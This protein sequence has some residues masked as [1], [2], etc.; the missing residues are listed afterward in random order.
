VLNR[1][2]EKEDRH[3]RRRLLAYEAMA[4]L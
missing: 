1:E 3:A 2:Q 4:R